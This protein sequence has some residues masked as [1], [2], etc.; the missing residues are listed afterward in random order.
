MGYRQWVIGGGFPNIIR[1]NEKTKKEG[2]KV[3]KFKVQL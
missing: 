1:D 2:A 3:R